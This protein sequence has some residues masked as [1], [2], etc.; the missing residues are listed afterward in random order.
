MEM[1][2]KK[3]K[4]A[5]VFVVADALSDKP[6]IEHFTAFPDVELCFLTLGDEDC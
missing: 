2:G 5:G 3:N 4:N 6:N 1:M